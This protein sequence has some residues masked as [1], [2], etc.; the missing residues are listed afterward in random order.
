MGHPRP[1]L[2]VFSRQLL[3]MRV[4]AGWPAAHVAEQ[5][6]ISRATAYKWVRRYRAEGED[7]LFD[8]TSRPH[9]SPRRTS[10]T[11][12]A[13][14]HLAARAE[15][16]YGPDRLGP[17][18]GRR[19][20]RPPGARETRLQPPARHRS[21]DG[22]ARP[23][24]RLPPGC[25]APPGPQEAGAHPRRRRL[26][27]RGTRQPTQ[28]GGTPTSGTSISRS[29][30]TTRVATPSS[31]PS[32]TRPSVGGLRARRSAAAEFARL[33][34]RI[35]R[36]LTDNGMAYT[37][38]RAYAQTLAGLGARHRRTRPYR[39]QTNGKAERVIQTLLNEWAYARPYRIERTSARQHSR[40]LSTSTIAGG[41]T[42]R[43]AGGHP[44]TL[45]TTSLADQQAKRA[46]C[47][48]ASTS[49]S[50]TRTGRSSTSAPCGAAGRT[51]WAHAWS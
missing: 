17:M 20:P 49:S 45:S 51:S 12:E 47:W 23:R 15:W 38:S 2:S 7:G 35:E 6:G 10:D 33:G 22:R 11:L 27:E 26:A 29:S 5:L 41:P 16:R 8:R 14:G 40:R 28:P 4:Q 50:S 9:R 18:S 31:S 43:S 46:T 48:P 25:A 3:V 34:I 21:G 13:R 1:R 19:P 37:R 24:R 36:V 44:S 39:P 30:S 32:P 42:R